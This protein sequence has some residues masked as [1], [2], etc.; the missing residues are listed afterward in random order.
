MKKTI[1]IKNAAILTASSLIL[2]FAGIM[3]KV[4]LAAKIGA[5]GIGLYQQIFSV[6]VLISTFASVGLCTAVTR[7][8]SEEAALGRKSGIVKILSRSILLILIIAFISLSII[9]FGSDF[10]AVR[11]LSDRRA[12]LSLKILGFS[13]PFMAVSSCFKGYFIALRKAT[14]PATAGIIEQTVRILIIIL[15]IDRLE[16]LNVETACAAVM[17]GDTIAEAVSALYIFILYI[18]GQKD[19][20]NLVGRT[21]PPYP[22]LKQ[23]IRISAP[24]TLGRYLNSSLRTIEN[25]LV[26]KTLAKYSATSNGLSQFGM[27]KGM[28]L[29]LLF[30]PSALLNSI[31]TLLIPEIS[32][33]AVCG[34]K[35]SLKTSIE[36]TI[37]IT[38]YTGLL[39]GAVFLILGKKIG[40]LIYK[41]TDVGFLISVLAPIVPLM[42]LDSIC[43]GI[44]KGLDA[45]MFCFRNSIIDSSIRI[46]LIC[47]L[48]ERFGLNAFIGIMYFSN[49][50][51]CFLNVGKL[52]KLS[53]AKINVLSGI[54]LPTVTSLFT[55]VFFDFVF[56]LLNAQNLLHIIFVS[57]LS[58]VSYVLLLISFGVITIPDCVKG[59]FE[60]KI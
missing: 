1:F 39:F 16:S 60:N 51:T 45:Q 19:L 40:I 23:L 15:I 31:S 36:R 48:L 2:R 37:S 26:P 46:L 35:Q 49:F 29:P 59:Y 27:I 8:I 12:A 55:V 20:N 50:L 54:L 47:V 7:L 9:Y 58:S 53:E 57:A 14:P 21:R 42:Y 56:K 13:L 38:L 10:I 22:V 6:Y 34:K 17:L 18:L 3:F 11:F 44:L 52:I 24:I 25:L 43:D 32:E 30:F 5:E 41:D 28:A 33:D 4:W